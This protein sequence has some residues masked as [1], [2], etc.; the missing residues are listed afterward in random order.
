MACKTDRHYHL[1][2]TFVYSS[3]T[4]KIHLIR[5][6]EDHNVFSKTASHV[7]CSFWKTPNKQIIDTCRGLSAKEES[8][9]EREEEEIEEEENNEKKKMKR[10]K[11]GWKKKNKKG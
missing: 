2:Q 4:S 9:A 7:F 10:K 5:A 8:L 6:V 11:K 1:K 3:K